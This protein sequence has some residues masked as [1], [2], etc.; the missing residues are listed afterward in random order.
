MG[1]PIILA[2]F[3]EHLLAADSVLCASNG[4]NSQKLIIIWLLLLIT[5]LKLE[6]PRKEEV[7]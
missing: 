2:T 3:M 1:Y 7:K 6:K 5:T 4:F